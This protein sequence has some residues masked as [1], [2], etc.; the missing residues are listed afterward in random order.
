MRSSADWH[1]MP[2]LQWAKV[3]KPATRGLNRNYNPMLKDVFKG[4]AATVIRKSAQEP[5]VQEYQRQVRV[6]MAGRRG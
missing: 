5:L 6:P 1:Q 2:D 4:A 3:N